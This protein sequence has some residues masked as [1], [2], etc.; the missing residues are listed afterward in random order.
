MKASPPSLVPASGREVD[1][2]P[3]AGLRLRNLRLDRI[4]RIRLLRVGRLGG[5]GAVIDVGPRLGG[6]P[7]VKSF[8]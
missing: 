8:R 7:R 5:F 2:V 4:Q 3:L 6:P 1:F